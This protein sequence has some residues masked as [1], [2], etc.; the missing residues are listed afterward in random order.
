[1]WESPG[2]DTNLPVS[3]MG[4]QISW[5]KSSYEV[6]LASIWNLSHF[7]PKCDFLLFIVSVWFCTDPYSYFLRIV[8]RASKPVGMGCGHGVRYWLLI[9]EGVMQNTESPDFRF[10]E[11]GVFLIAC[12]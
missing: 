1:M 12:E 2:Y 11:V 10:S 6:L 3:C 9:F 8:S 4:H 7:L 5:I